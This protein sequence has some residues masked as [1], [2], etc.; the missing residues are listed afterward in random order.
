MLK[1]LPSHRAANRLAKHRG[2]RTL[3][4]REREPDLSTFRGRLG[5]NVRTRRKALGLSQ[6]AL[7]AR[8]AQYGVELTVPAISVYEGGKRPFQ[9]DHLPALAL[10]LQTTI[11]RLVP[12][13]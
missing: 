5:A 8:L 2:D 4:N 13:K 11:H 6:G 12:N 10:A 7:S 9:T 1:S 3:A